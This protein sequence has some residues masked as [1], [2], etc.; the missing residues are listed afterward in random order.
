M[1]RVLR[2]D[3]VWANLNPVV[4]HEQAGRRPVVVL[5]ADVFNEHSGTVIAM[6]MTVPECSLNTSAL[7]TTTG[8]RP[9]CS[10]PTTGFRLAQTISPL[11][12]RA[13]LQSPRPSLRRPSS[14]RQTCSAWRTRAPVGLARAGRACRGRPLGSRGSDSGTCVGDKAVDTLQEL[15]FD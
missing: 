15:C 12:T 7:R 5:S 1:A 3:I 13:I 9:A 6:A 14:A 11:R 10:W 8:R 4:G 2:G